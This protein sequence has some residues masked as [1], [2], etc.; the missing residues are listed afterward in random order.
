[1][2]FPLTVRENISFGLEMLG[3]PKAEIDK[4]VHDM[5]ELVHI[6]DL[7]ANA[8]SNIWWT[9]AKGSTCAGVSPKARRFTA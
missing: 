8:R 7:K 4:T 5:L 9:A 2:L 6:Q 1:M 3:K